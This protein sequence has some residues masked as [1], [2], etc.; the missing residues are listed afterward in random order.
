MFK[1]EGTI[2]S[3]D[4]DSNSERSLTSKR[5]N[6][7]KI[8]KQY[9]YALNRQSKTSI[10]LDR[11]VLELT[12]VELQLQ[13]KTPLAHSSV[14]TSCSSSSVVQQSGEEGDKQ[15]P[16]ILNDNIGSTVAELAYKGFINEIKDEELTVSE[17]NKD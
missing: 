2:L 10:V 8:K 11:L 12:N 5:K 14:S 1:E 17:D 6:K 13:S 16:S 7:G 9:C 3:T 4:N 15:Q